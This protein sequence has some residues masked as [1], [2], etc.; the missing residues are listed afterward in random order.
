[1][2]R[3]L[4]REQ[5]YQLAITDP[6]TGCYNRRFFG[7]VMPR[8]LSRRERYRTTLSLLFVDV[9]NLKALNDT[10]GHA[11]GDELLRLLASYLAANIRRSDYLFRWGGD[12]FLILTCC[13]GPAARSKARDLKQGFRRGLPDTVP[14]DIGLSIGWAE[15]GPDGEEEAAV[16]RVADKRMYEDKRKA[17]QV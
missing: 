4:T 6:L 5:M 3:D 10:Q 9:D 8:E 16:V 7:E 15:V 12:E 17:G 13:S 11:A 1:M 14:A 2:D